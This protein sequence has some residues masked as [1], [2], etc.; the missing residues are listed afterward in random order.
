MLHDHEQFFLG[1]DDLIELD[2]VRMSDFLEDLDLSCDSLNI[3]LVV[4]LFFLKNLD[5]YLHI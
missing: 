1:L 3:L 5:S 2:N 4:D